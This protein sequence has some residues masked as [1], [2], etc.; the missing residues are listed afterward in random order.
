MIGI[1][2]Y[3]YG[4]QPTRELFSG[5]G[6]RAVEDDQSSTR[7]SHLRHKSL[8]QVYVQYTETVDLGIIEVDILYSNLQQTK[9]FF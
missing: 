2:I 4:I 6:L 5:A 9:I 8:R 1:L 3:F 7:F